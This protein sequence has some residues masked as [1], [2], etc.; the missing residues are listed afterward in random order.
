MAPCQHFL[1]NTCFYYYLSTAVSGGPQAIRT[2]CPIAKCNDLIAP[3][4]FQKVVSEEDYGMYKK[5]YM[6]YFV[7]CCKAIKWCPSPGCE[8]AVHYP[9]LTAID[10]YCD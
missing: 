5:F 2:V 10:V 8:K 9:E 3:S 6:N 7:D 1:C 4:L